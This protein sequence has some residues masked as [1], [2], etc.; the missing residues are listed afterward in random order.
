MKKLYFLAVLCIPAL[1]HADV[2][3]WRDARGR[4]HYSNVSESV[5]AHA[6]V[7]K[8]AIGSLASDLP[9]PDAKAIEADLEAYGKLHAQRAARQALPPPPA[10]VTYSYGWPGGVAVTQVVA[11]TLCQGEFPC[12]PSMLLSHNA[13]VNLWLWQARWELAWR[14]L[15]VVN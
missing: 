10:P 6:T 14:E 11:P 9:A 2:W 5:P 13:P 7:V 8:G 1:V 4:L 3:R 12:D 15:G